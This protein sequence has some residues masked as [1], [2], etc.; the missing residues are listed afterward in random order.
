MAFRQILTLVLVLSITITFAQNRRADLDRFF[1]DLSKNK[2]FNGNVLIAEKGKIIYERSFGY[3][4]FSKKVLNDRT[5]RFPIASITKS[6]TATAILQLAENH[7]LQVNDPVTKYLPAFPYPALT[8]KNL[9]SHTSGLPPYGRFFDSVRL[10]NPDTVFTNKDVLPAYARLQ[11]PLFYQP[12]DDSN[13]DNI[14]YLFLALV[15]EQVAGIPYQDY[16]REYILKPAGMTSTFFPTVAFYHYTPQ[17]S[18]R[19]ASLY[20]YPHYYSASFEKADTVH[21]ISSYWHTYNLQGFGEIVSTTEDLLKY[22]QAFYKG[23]LL[24]PAS[25]SIAYA[26]V[27]LNSGVPNKGNGNGSS[28]GLGWIVE[29]DTSLGKIVRGSGGAIGL[30]ASFIRNITKRQTIILFDN[31][32]N[33]TDAIG[34][35]VLKIINGKKV[36]PYRKSAAKEFGSVLVADGYDKAM[37]AFRTIRKDTV[38]Y[39]I[40]ENEFNSMGYDLMGN[41]YLKEALETFKLNVT[42]FPAS[43]NVYDSYGEALLKHGQKEEAIKMYKRSIELNPGNDNGK[44]VLAQI[45]AAR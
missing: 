27:L 15:I 3:A 25:F 35:N 32:Q 22:D 18:T 1:T 7:K 14:N 41:G 34:K 44:K 5:T 16:V 19:L 26:P 30:R 39:R 23:K 10:K 12:G 36:Q 33:E 6:F 8:I 4:D 42:L 20:W 9:L 43:W 40:D 17:E 38:R 21:F 2:Q 31:T 28:F 37:A 11:L 13:Y 45:G 29:A 24:K